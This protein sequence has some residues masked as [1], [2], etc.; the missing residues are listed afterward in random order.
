MR[1]GDAEACERADGVGVGA[2]DVA[3]DDGSSF[4]FLRTQ[5]SVSVTRGNN[6]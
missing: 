1:G 5:P 3:D 2:F 6:V 4:L